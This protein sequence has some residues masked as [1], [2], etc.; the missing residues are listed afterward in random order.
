MSSR[1]GSFG[2][3]PGGLSRSATSTSTSPATTGNTDGIATAGA[4]VDL[5]SSYGTLALSTSSGLK[6]SV[7]ASRSSPQQQGA[8]Q[9]IY[10]SHDYGGRCALQTG[11][12]G[13]PRS[14]S[15]L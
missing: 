4:G 6:Q 11:V 9:G 13:Q 2:S 3:A 10:G 1:N 12:R 15:N 14:A 7:F 8:S 5:G